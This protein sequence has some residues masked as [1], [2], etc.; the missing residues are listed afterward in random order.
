MKSIKSGFAALPV[1][2]EI[3]F[4]AGEC[5]QRLL[6][7]HPLRDD[8]KKLSNLR[9]EGES[10][11]FKMG[12][13]FYKKESLSPKE[14]LLTTNQEITFKNQEIVLPNQEMMPT[15]Q[16]ITFKNQEIVLPN[17]EMMP[18]NQEMML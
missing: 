11:L 13:S 1:R 12:M 8:R 10:L 15:N 6:L 14:E 7:K 4:R 9:F 17:Q 3:H 16:G 5:D 18:T 2:P